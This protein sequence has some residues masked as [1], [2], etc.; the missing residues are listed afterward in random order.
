V[1]LCRVG[2]A[3]HIT[4]G[5]TLIKLLPN[6]CKDTKL[7]KKY[8]YI[9]FL[10]RAFRA[11]EKLSLK[12]LLKLYPPHPHLINSSTPGGASGEAPSLAPPYDYQPPT[13]SR[14][15]GR[16]PPKVEVSKILPPSLGRGC[17]LKT[18]STGKYL[19]LFI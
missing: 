3:Y 4:L 16:P 11:R 2:F 17:R 8:I 12:P 1:D 15:S 13:H 9:Y 5:E 7:K 18:Q 19:I 10:I 14:P 6:L